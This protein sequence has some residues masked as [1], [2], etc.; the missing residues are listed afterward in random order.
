MA[1]KQTRCPDEKTDPVDKD[2]TRDTASRVTNTNKPDDIRVKGEVKHHH[3][4]QVEDVEEETD[5][6]SSE[7]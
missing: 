4:E 6:A 7:L 5:E 2:T 3:D 1:D